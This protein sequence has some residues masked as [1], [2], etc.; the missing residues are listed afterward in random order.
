MLLTGEIQNFNQAEN[1]LREISVDD[2]E[3]IMN[4]A[5]Q[6][7]ILARKAIAEAERALQRTQ[8]YFRST[9]IDPEAMIRHLEEQGGLNAKREIESMVEVAIQDVKREAETAIREARKAELAPPAK[10]RI[11]QLI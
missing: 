1:F 9:G 3:E 11:R 4:K 6:A 2:D 5:R 7:A 10:R 8:D